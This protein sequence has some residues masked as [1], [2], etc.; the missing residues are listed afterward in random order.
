MRESFTH[1]R[2]MQMMALPAATRK[3]STKNEIGAGGRGA[4]SFTRY[5]QNRTAGL[6]IQKGMKLNELCEIAWSPAVLLVH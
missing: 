1:N 4:I 2:H 5:K 3:S 6:F